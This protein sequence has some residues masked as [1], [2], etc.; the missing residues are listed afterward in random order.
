[1]KCKININ[2]TF[3]YPK[4]GEEEIACQIAYASTPSF[5]V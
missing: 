5:H 3:D 4:F 1:M 2:L